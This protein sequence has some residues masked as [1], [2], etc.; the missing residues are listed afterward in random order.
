VH[1]AVRG[2][3]TGDLLSTSS[4]SSASRPPHKLKQ[5]LA[6]FPHRFGYGG[7]GCT[8]HPHFV[9]SV[10]EAG[11]RFL[12]A[13][14]ALFGGLTG[15]L[16]PAHVPWAWR[17]HLFHYCADAFLDISDVEEYEALLGLCDFIVANGR[18]SGGALRLVIPSTSEISRNAFRANK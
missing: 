11:G 18:V 5:H 4:F 17:P 7:A 15:A 1:L 16:F 10:A 9:P 12:A 8:E 13:R 3:P 14:T 2:R 6:P